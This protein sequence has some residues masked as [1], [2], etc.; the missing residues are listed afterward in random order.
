MRVKYNQVMLVQLTKMMK[1][2]NIVLGK[3]QGQSIL[4][5]YWWNWNLSQT[6]ENQ[7]ENMNLIQAGLI[8]PLRDEHLQ[9]RVSLVAYVYEFIFFFSKSSAHQII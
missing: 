2:Q 7:C 5:S 4:I 9:D 3:L 8:A 1:S 6:W